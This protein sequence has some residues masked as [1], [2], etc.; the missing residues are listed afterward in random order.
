MSNIPPNK[1]NFSFESHWD[2][3]KG[4][5]KNEIKENFTDEEWEEKERKEKENERRIR[6]QT[7]LGILENDP[8]LVQEIIMELRKIKIKKLKK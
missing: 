7:V 2:W 6:K 4:K 8:E 5:W 1:N 3:F